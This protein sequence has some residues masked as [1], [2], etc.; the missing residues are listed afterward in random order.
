MQI[1]PLPTARDLPP[2][3]SLSNR[4]QPRVDAGAQA[5]RA[6]KLVA[7]PRTSRNLAVR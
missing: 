1:T 3:T 7:L 5:L 2:V 6:D 4:A